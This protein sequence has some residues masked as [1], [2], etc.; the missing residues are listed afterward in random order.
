MV[1]IFL[2]AI[3]PIKIAILQKAYVAWKLSSKSVVMIYQKLFFYDAWWLWEN[4]IVMLDDVVIL[5]SNGCL[6]FIIQV[7]FMIS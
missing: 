1:N 7:H 4:V 3:L 2:K 5:S 6:L